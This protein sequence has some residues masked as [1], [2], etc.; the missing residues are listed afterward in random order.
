[1]GAILVENVLLWLVW[2][3]KEIFVQIIHA[4]ISYLMMWCLHFLLEII[5]RLEFSL[6]I[7]LIRSTCRLIGLLLL[8]IMVFICISKGASIILL[9][10]R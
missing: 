4:L 10:R 1:M 3:L 6:K 7:I 2:T 8:M 9:G 5:C